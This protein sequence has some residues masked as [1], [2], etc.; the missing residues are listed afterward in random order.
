MLWVTAKSEDWS[1]PNVYA[2]VKSGGRQYKAEPGKQIITEKL[3]FEAGET[4]NFA[5]VLL[6]VNDDGSATIGQPLVQGVVVR[7]TVVEHYR[8]KK[9]LVYHYNAKHR[10]R[11]RRGHR[12][13]YTRLQIESITV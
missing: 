7:A 10:V 11:K 13:T 4:I 2:I 9:I 5:D 8:A 6:V 12:Q 3:K 1:N